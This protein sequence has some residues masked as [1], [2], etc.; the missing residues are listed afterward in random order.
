MARFETTGRKPGIV[1]QS[2]SSEYLRSGPPAKLAYSLVEFCALHGISRA[3]F[4]NLRKLGLGPR[5]MACG[6]RKLISVEAAS[7]WRRQRERP[8]ESTT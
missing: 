6:S 8:S 2:G 4:Y 7:D 3:H 1:D 5:E